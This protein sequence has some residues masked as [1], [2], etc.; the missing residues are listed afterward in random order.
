MARGNNAAK[1]LAMLTALAEEVR[2]NGPPPSAVK[3]IPPTVTDVVEQPSMTQAMVKS[4]MLGRVYQRAL[5]QVH[6]QY[7]DVE[8]GKAV[9]LAICPTC[10]ES[11]DEKEQ[12]GL[13]EAHGVMKNGKVE[14]PLVP[15]SGYMCERCDEKQHTLFDKVKASQERL[16][17]QRAI[18]A[19]QHYPS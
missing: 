19:E 2:L 4:E 13:L 10:S 18:D 17:L 11:M 9:Y 6:W 1:V 14:L 16:A 12:A 3:D 7:I 8:D 15:V 5:V